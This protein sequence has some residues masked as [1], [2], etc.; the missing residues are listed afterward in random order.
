MSDKRPSRW[1]ANKG[2]AKAILHDRALRRRAMGRS[3]LLLLAVFASGL[4]AIDG[5]LRAD[6]LRF[7]IWWGGC[8]ALCIFVVLFALYDVLAV[9]REERE[10]R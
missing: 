10:G 6:L 7:V 1:S 2:F 4:W 3:V 8:G 9:I 5:W